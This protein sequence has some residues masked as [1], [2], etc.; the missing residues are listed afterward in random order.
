MLTL[1]RLLC[2]SRDQ[3]CCA[4]RKTAGL[5]SMRMHRL[6]SCDYA[7]GVTAISMMSETE[8]AGGKYGSK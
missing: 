1:G 5:G 4:L 2:Q 6:G 8:T 3:P 7:I